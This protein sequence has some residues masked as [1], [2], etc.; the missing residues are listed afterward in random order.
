MTPT[1]VRKLRLQGDK[2]TFGRDAVV[3]VGGPGERRTSG[4]LAFPKVGPAFALVAVGNSID[5][6]GLA[7]VHVSDPPT[8]DEPVTWSFYPGGLDPAAVAASHGI[9]PIRVARARPTS[10]GL[11]ASQ[12]LELGQL[13]AAGSF[14]PKCILSES[15]YVKDVDL[16]I[17]AQGAMW[18]FW[19]DTR[20]SHF[21]RRALP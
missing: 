4:A 11:D 17:D 9:S 1:H 13:D 19:R 2:L 21:E 8:E 10:P 5:K 6:F 18:I 20:G 12:V 14:V 16:D 15:A 3:F 7:A